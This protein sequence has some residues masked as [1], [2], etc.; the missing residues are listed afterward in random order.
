MAEGAAVNGEV[1]P[2]GFFATFALGAIALLVGQFSGI[3]AISWWYD[4]DLKQIASVSQHGG[5]IILFILVSAPAQVAVL[6][7]AAGYKGHAA[8]YLGYKLPRSS[9]GVFGIAALAV[10]TVI[11]AAVRWRAG[12]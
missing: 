9:E 6:L 10:V 11:R 1:K 4:L 5:A 3:A 2:W 8:E 7:A 12:A